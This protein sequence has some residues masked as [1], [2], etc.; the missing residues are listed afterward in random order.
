M[1]NDDIFDKLSE[2]LSGISKTSSD[3]IK[4]T[5]EIKLSGP[6]NIFFTNNLNNTHKNMFSKNQ[7]SLDYF[8]KPKSI[9]VFGVS[10]D[11][12]K[13]G[14]VV[15]NNLI[16]GGYEGKLYPINPKYTELFNYQAYAKITDIDEPIELAIIVIPSQ[17]VLDAM[18][19]CAAK[20]VKAVII[21]SSGFKETGEAGAE[22]EKD[23]VKIAKDANI[24]IIGPNCL[25]V[26]SPSTK[27]NASFATG[28]PT[29][30]NIAFLSQ[31]GAICTALLD[32]AIPDNL[33]F[34]DFVSFGN[35][36]DVNEVELIELWSDDNDIKVIGAYLEEIKYGRDFIEAIKKCKN[37]KPV[38]VLKPGQTEQAKKAIASHT[39]ALAGSIETFKTALE[40][41]NVI[42]ACDFNQMY[43][44]LMR[45]A[46]GKR[47][48]GRNVAIVTN[49]GG[50]GIIATD[51]IIKNGLKIAVLSEQTQAELGEI[52][53]PS[54]NIHNPVD[55]IG[56]A[57]ADRYRNSIDILAKAPEVD[58]IFVLI[59]PQLV[60]QIEDTT[61]SIILASRKY[62]KPIYP[63]LLGK[64][65]MLA[66]IQ[67]F[68]DNK[69]PV[70]TDITEAV[71]QLAIH[72]NYLE[73]N[74]EENITISSEEIS[75]M[76]NNRQFK[77]LSE[78]FDSNEMSTESAK[79]PII[80]S[81]DLSY[82]IAIE[83]GLPMTAQKVSR[84]IEDALE[85]A[86][87]NFPVVIKA[88]N[89]AIPH[90]TD[91]KAL[92]T[93]I[94]NEQEFID[95]YRK[96]E[97]TIREIQGENYKG[98]IEILVQKQISY[99]EQIFIGA[100][101]DGDKNV[102]EN[103]N[104]GFGHL[105][106]YGQGG[107]YT[108]IYKDIVYSL[109]PTDEKSVLTNLSKTKIFNILNGARGN[110]PLATDKVVKA[111]LAVQ[112]MIL[113][114]PEIVSVDINPLLVTQDDV[115]AV[116]IKIFVE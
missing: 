30:G 108:E 49:A 71:E 2:L 74:N 15:F 13:L 26:I 11:P 96:L 80:L 105:I 41:N 90:K 31:S 107:I 82:K 57:L 69:I 53:P 32:S 81:E 42:E 37:K 23:I 28:M 54:S 70:Y 75:K 87:E 44:L 101:R 24:R 76:R 56:D 103:N 113:L 35:K 36:A 97:N 3:N 95:A 19:D 59:T 104:P 62:D 67:D 91:K 12:S 45:F 52:L 47:P 111:I 61:R 20:K 116:D 38:I 22:L 16:F 100:N 40:Q 84:N 115:F 7:D 72:I 94:N 51:Q 64:K 66:A 10:E 68:L 85:F 1:K 34:R 8:F 5:D 65:H 6:K 29:T 114:Y 27:L 79:G 106:A 86:K 89:R 60:T 78:E 4:G 9:A 88:T 21:I 92:Y 73:R 63:V 33:G 43:S 112:K 55:V 17:Y 14:S 110:S 83:A 58:A 50:P 39:G 48:A 99:K 98:G 93:N 109:A 102:Y 46:W 77:S 25:G 18:K